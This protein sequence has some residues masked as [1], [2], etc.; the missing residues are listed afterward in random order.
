M[1][2][3]ERPILSPR[4]CIFCPTGYRGGP[5]VDTLFEHAIPPVGRVYVCMEHA[6]RLA[7]AAGFAEGEE[8]DRLLKAAQLVATA[9]ADVVKRD[10]IIGSLRNQIA[11]QD[12]SI[13]QLEQERAD[14]EGRATQAEGKLAE[15]AAELAGTAAA[16]AR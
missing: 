5:V 7:I 6:K 4:T 2:K 16:V 8:M 9:E 3:V 10:K 11:A 15:V 1:R 12:R 13:A 14:A